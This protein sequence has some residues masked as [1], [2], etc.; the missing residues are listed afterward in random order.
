MSFLALRPPHPSYKALATNDAP[1]LQIFQRISE[2]SSMSP[3]ARSAR[4]SK[5]GSPKTFL[6]PDSLGG[7]PW[8]AQGK[9][10]EKGLDSPPPGPQTV[11]PHHHQHLP[12]TYYRTGSF[13][14][15]YSTNVHKNPTGSSS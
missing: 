8:M 5:L 10:A 6:A 14:L 12:S 11:K 2:Q 7:I 15:L 13:P 3:W 9:E 4:E 1:G